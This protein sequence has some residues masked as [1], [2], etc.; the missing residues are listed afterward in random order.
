[1]TR[2]NP[3]PTFGN[4]VPWP[5]LDRQWTAELPTVAPATFLSFRPT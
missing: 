5:M 3:Q 4:F 1:M 2:A